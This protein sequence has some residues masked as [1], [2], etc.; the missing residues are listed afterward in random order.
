MKSP[1]PFL[2]VTVFLNIAG[3][4]LILPLLPFYGTLFNASP[5]AC[6]TTRTSTLRN[7][8]IRRWQ[9]PSIPI[10]S[11]KSLSRFAPMTMGMKSTPLRSCLRRLAR[12]RVGV[13]LLL[14]ETSGQAAEVLFNRNREDT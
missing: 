14:V 12:M 4:S 9:S 5:F 11:V 1:L 2:L 6:S 13:G 10:G 3:F 7:I 8:S